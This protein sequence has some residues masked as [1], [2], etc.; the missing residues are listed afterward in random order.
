MIVINGK[1]IAESIRKGIK[2]EVLKLKERGITPTLH[3]II[4]GNDKASKTYVGVKERYSKEV[5]M[6]FELD[7]VP[8]NITEHKLI[9]KIDELNKNKAIN[10]IIV[11][12]PLPNHINRHNILKSI[13]PKKDVDALNPFNLGNLFF[14]VDGLSAATAKGIIKLLEH[15]GIEVKG[16]SVTII[17]RSL[18]VGKPLAHLFLNKDATVTICHSKTVGLERYTKNSDIVVCAVGKP[19]F[20]TK[21]MVKENSII[22]DVGLTY[23]NEKGVGDVDFEN[24]K[25]KV[26][27]ITPVPFG[28]G[29]MTVAMILENL[30]LL[31]KEQFNL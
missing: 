24:V 28:V 1:K 11:Q 26:A 27:Y 16:K 9:N 25:E 23:V 31:T 29:P 12:L 18:N 6:K 2:D 17:N 21:E 4:V 5:G 14:G 22:I 19:N 20:L 3:I 10:G 13:D 30:V 8:E 15:E 7:E